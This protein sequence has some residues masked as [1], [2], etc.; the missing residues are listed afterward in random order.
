MIGNLYF[1][2]YGK[3]R[4]VAENVTEQEAIVIRHKFL[5]DRDFKC[6]YVR[7]WKTKEGIMYDVGS[8]SEFFLW[9]KQGE[10]FWN[11]KE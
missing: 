3:Y 8:W 1:I 9:G 11:D 2:N 7:S 6:Y 5:E 10:E 4:L